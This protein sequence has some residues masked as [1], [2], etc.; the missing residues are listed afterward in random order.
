MAYSVAQRTAEIGIRQA[1]GAQRGDILRMVMGQALRLSLAG[2]AIGVMA[3]AGLTRL[4][5]GML[6]HTSA[7][8]PATYIG[9]SLLFLPLRWR[10][11]TCRHGAPPG[12][13]RWRRCAWDSRRGAIDNY[14]GGRA[15]QMD[16]SGPA[17]VRVPVQLRGPAGDLFGIPA[18]QSGDAPERRA[19]GV[20]RLLVHVG[21]R[22]GG[23]FRRDGGRSLPPETRD[24]GR[25]DFLVADYGGDGALHDATGIWW[26]FGRWRDWARRSTFRPRC[27]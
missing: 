15:V 11:V 20:R 12:S 1:I 23:A 4:I 22:R 14:G 26:C 13:T 10:R 6:Y 7:T 3:A 21:V 27:R 24:S 16:G 19:I 2:I 18:A 25:A 5:A 17:V 9:I 8:D